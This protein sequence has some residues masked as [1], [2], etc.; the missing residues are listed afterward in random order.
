MAQSWQEHLTIRQ[1]DLTAATTDAIVNAA[2]NDLLL[3]GGVAGAI[4]TKGGPSIQEECRRHGSIRIGEA[5][6]TGGGELPARYVIHAASMQLGGLT[7]EQALRDSTRNAL[8]LAND[9]RL[10][11]IAFP[12]IG[13]GIAGFPLK[14]CAQVMLDEIR[15][16]LNRET[17]L[18]RVEI[19]LFDAPALAVFNETLAQ[20]DRA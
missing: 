11:S 4:R 7:S 6:I 13:T 20:M 9:Y 3:G 10:E 1:G 8:R 16:H 18:R 12:A 5:A 19:V 17:T 2:N 15:S 14:R